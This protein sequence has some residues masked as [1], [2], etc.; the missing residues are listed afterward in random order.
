MLRPLSRRGGSDLSALAP[1]HCLD[2]LSRLSPPPP[3]LP[4]PPP[5]TPQ[6]YLCLMA[7]PTAEVSQLLQG[8]P[9]VVSS[10]WLK[11]CTAVGE[12]WRQLDK[13]T[14]SECFT[15][16]VWPCWGWLSREVT[17]EAGW[18]WGWGAGCG[19]LS[20]GD[21][22]WRTGAECGGLG[23]GLVLGLHYCNE[24]S[25]TFRSDS[26]VSSFSSH[27]TSLQPQN[28]VNIPLLGQGALLVTVECVAVALSRLRQ[29][30]LR[31]VVCCCGQLSCS[32]TVG[33][34]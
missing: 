7:V 34:A 21:W 13:D 33:C 20:V 18:D 30:G 31:P 12:A 25:V 29:S 19:G 26:I 3:P 16:F 17:W 11:L 1:S 15:C 14:F 6:R 22:V 23:M 10:L 28:R 24:M 8:C 27:V 9:A 4:L 32:S 5:P 2:A